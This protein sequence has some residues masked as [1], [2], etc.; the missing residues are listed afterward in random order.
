MKRLLNFIKSGFR[1]LGYKY[2]PI[3]YWYEGK[4]KVGYVITNNYTFFWIPC[5][6]RVSLCI[7][8]EEL[9]ETIKKLN[10]L[11]KTTMYLP[12]QHL[13]DQLAP[14]PRR[15]ICSSIDHQKQSKKW[16]VRVK[17][18]MLMKSDSKPLCQMLFR[19]W[20]KTA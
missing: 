7:S 1:E 14:K 13:K 5:Y 16:S 4:P 19:I 15:R 20:L 6:D 11:C 10:L 8:K 18:Q 3:I 2:H 12:V 17:I 9:E